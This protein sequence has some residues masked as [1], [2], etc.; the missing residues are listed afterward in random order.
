MQSIKVKDFSLEHTLECSQFFRLTKENEFY[1][2]SHGEN[3][4]KVAQKGNKLFFE[5]ASAAYVRK[6]FSLDEDYKKIIKSIQKDSHINRV[7]DEYR[8]LRLIKQEPWECLVSYV[9]SANSSVAKVQNN[10]ARF[11]TCIAKPRQREPTIH[12]TFPKNIGNQKILK[13]CGAGFRAKYLAQINNIV[14][15]E[16]FEKIDKMSYPEASKFLQELPG[17]GQKVSDCVLLFA[18]KKYQAFPVDVWVE[19]FMKKHYPECRNL[20]LPKIAEFGRGYFGK[21]AGYAQQFLYYHA[22]LHPK[23]YVKNE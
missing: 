10:L 16:F 11:A 21:Y 6:F 22:F 18:Y 14:D 5:G 23:E 7:I 1:K 2:I 12:Y 13:S 20:S 17:V 19:R 4:F 8:G 9:L 15:D 3:S